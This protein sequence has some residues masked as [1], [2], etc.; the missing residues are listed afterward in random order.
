MAS[1]VPDGAQDALLCL[2]TRIFPFPIPKGKKSPGL[3]AKAFAAM[4]TPPSTTA[5]ME[6]IDNLR[7]QFL[8]EI[9]QQKPN[10][11]SVASAAD[12]YAPQVHRI[13]HSIDASV[14]CMVSN[15]ME[16]R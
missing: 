13:I 15:Q 5:T 11:A 14:S 7:N 2:C 8:D 4:G 10:Q 9:L 3:Y 1:P 6:A 12:R 16:L